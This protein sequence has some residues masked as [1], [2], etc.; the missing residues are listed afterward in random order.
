MTG[1]G[2]CEDQRA[3]VAF[4]TGR[5]CDCVHSK[6][7]GR[8]GPCSGSRRR[9]SDRQR[10]TCTVNPV[11]LVRAEPGLRMLPDS[12][13]VGRDLATAVAGPSHFRIANGK[14]EE[15]GRTANR[16]AECTPAGKESP[17]PAFSGRRN[18]VSRDSRSSQSRTHRTR[19]TNPASQNQRKTRHITATAPASTAAVP[20]RRPPREPSR[21]PR[22]R[23]A[24]PAA[25]SAG[26]AVPPGR[27]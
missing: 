5:Q 19:P 23:C 17:H 11:Q 13:L 3:Q 2:N 20:P 15:P 9:Q 27:S 8:Q 26:R 14:C 7:S 21:S 1:I 18:A 12:V 4:V 10:A 25:A 6:F 24:P 22:A 16:F